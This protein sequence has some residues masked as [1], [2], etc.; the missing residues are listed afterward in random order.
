MRKHGYSE[1][2]YGGLRLESVTPMALFH[3]ARDWFHK[4]LR[5]KNMLSLFENQVLGDFNPLA[6]HCN[7]QRTAAVL[8]QF[9]GAVR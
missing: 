4:Y 2:I 8:L 6:I 7:F 1:E 5:C 3:S 9:E